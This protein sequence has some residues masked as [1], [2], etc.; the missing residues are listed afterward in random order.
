[1]K[2]LIT[3]IAGFLGSRFAAWLLAHVPEA[4]VV[5]VDDLSCGYSENV[6][7]GVRWH[8]FSLGSEASTLDPR[9]STLNPRPSTLPALAA[10]DYVFHFAAYAAEGLS[11]FI[12]CF[13]YR[14]NLVATAEVINHAIRAGTVKRF[15]FT[16]SMAVYGRGRAPFDERDPLTPI[17]P[18]GVAKA[19]CERDL[20]IAGEQHGLDWCVVRPHNLYGPCQ[21]LWQPYRNVLGIWMSRRLEGLPLLVYGDGSQRRAFSFIDDCLPCLWRAAIEPA[22]SGQT[23]NL[24]GTRPVEIGRAVRMVCELTG[25]GVIAHR[26]PRHE[27]AEAWCEWR[28]SAELVGYNEGGETPLAEGLAR[29]WAWARDAW[30]RYPDRRGR[31]ERFEVEIERGLYSYWKR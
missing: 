2:I 8:R 1:M 5:G 14:N 23:I 13:N 3:G 12:R 6:P 16:S 20:A 25:G 27:V 31:P 9:P 17:D 22:C 18:Y 28:K 11:P 19:A 21:S 4:E 29:M 24:G 30:Q 15:V 7:P 10:P 26:E